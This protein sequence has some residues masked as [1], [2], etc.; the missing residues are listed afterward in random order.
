MKK[1]V[2]LV[3]F[4]FILYSSCQSKKV[5]IDFQQTECKNLV[6]K[7]AVYSLEKPPCDNGKKQSYLQNTIRI[8][9]DHNNK[10]PCLEFF[11]IKAVFLRSDGTE[12]S[13]VSYKSDYKYT[14]PEVTLTSSYIE[15]AFKYTLATTDDADNLSTI[16]IDLSLE[17]E[18]KDVSKFFTLTVPL[19]CVTSSSNGSYQVVQDVHV[20]SSTVTLG[21][22]DYSSIDGDIISV[23][24]N[25]NVVVSNLTLT[26]SFQNF[27]VTVNSGSNQ[28][29]VIAENEGSSSPNT[30][31][32]KVNNSS[33][34][35]LTPG[36]N[37]GQGINIIF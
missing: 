36:L 25:G 8:K 32:V 22:R 33:G 13:G 17:N 28:L 27:T 1:I 34:I 15:I 18:L 31:E 26:G 14:D 2:T 19:S 9:V 24:L 5:K 29:V 30:C 3:L 11:K 35:D 21:F 12:I 6:L 4:V 10:Q 7:N 16:K 23:Y 20:N 37:T